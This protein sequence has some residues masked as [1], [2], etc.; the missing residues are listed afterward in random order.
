MMLDHKDYKGDHTWSEEFVIKAN[1]LVD[2][3]KELIESG[4]VRRIIIRN[5]QDDVL[6]EIPLTAGVAVGG[7]LTIFTPVL[8]ALGAMAAL[9]ADIKIQII[10]QQ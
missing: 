1:E 3:V 4:N 8:A 5:A 2:K 10:R 9:L 6:L 7:V